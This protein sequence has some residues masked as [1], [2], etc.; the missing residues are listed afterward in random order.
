MIDTRSEFEWF[1]MGI[2][3]AGSRESF[4]SEEEQDNTVSIEE[5]N[6]TVT[7]TI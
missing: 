7:M 5:T 6:S 2:A 3:V 1:L 4:K